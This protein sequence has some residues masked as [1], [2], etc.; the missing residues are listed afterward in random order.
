MSKAAS[1]PYPEIATLLGGRKLLGEEPD[2]QLGFA[3]RIARGLPAGSVLRLKEALGVTEADLA[4]LLGVST[5]TLARLRLGIVKSAIPAGNSA[6]ATRVQAQQILDPVLSDRAYRLAFLLAR[7]RQLLGEV[8]AVQWLRTPQRGIAGRVP[9][10]LATTEAGAR[11][12]E[13]LLHR[14]SHGVYA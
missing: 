2:T 6:R 8:G 13:A 9:L 4:R 10:D 7:A 14:I 3:D 11:E 1:L 5:R 12:V